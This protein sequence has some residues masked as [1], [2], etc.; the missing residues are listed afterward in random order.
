[1]LMAVL[2][3]VL[4]GVWTVVAVGVRMLVQLRRTGDTGFRGVSGEFGSVEWWIAA[5][6][7]GAVAAGLAGPVV[8][9]IG[10]WADFSLASAAYV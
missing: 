7:T 10:P 4:F 5:L 9:L 1:M 8:D 3:L 2:A 6:F